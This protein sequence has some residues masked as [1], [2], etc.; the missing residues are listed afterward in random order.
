V[1]RLRVVAALHMVR[2]Q[3]LVTGAQVVSCVSDACVVREHGVVHA[4]VCDSGGRLWPR[5][6]NKEK[7]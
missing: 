3:E 7:K 4:M 1:S 2:M 6:I 5:R